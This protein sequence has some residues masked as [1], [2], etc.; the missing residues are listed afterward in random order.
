MALNGTLSA[1]EMS[2][3]ADAPIVRSKDV[4]LG[5]SKAEPAQHRI[6]RRGIVGVEHR[7]RDVA[8]GKVARDVGEGHARRRADG[9]RERIGRDE[10]LRADRDDD[11]V[12]V[13]PRDVTSPVLANGERM[14]Q[15]PGLP[16]FLLCQRFWLPLT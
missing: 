7:A 1:G 15:V 5:S 16:L 10:H 9:G 13:G 3:H 8:A 6:N 4:P 14:R 2:V 11:V 12:A